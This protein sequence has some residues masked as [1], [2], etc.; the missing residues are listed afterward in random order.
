MN[1]KYY[2][3]FAI[4]FLSLPVIFNLARADEASATKPQ[5][6]IL[7]R[8]SVPGTDNQLGMELIQFPPNSIK[9]PHIHS[10]AEIIYVLQG[11][12]TFRVQ[13]QPSKTVKAG[14]SF[15]IPIGVSHN[16]QVGPHGAKLIAAWVMK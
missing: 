13:G 16:T 8:T 15:Q 2:K 9:S 10:W 11:E 1:K 4:I 6:Q 14:E 5:T 7:Q 3:Y 12:I